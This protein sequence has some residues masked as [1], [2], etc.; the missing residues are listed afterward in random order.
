VHPPP[1]S[2]L[3]RARP[4]RSGAELANRWIS[5]TA[6]CLFKLGRPLEALRLAESAL[7]TSCSLD[8]QRF[9]LRGLILH[10]LRRYGDAIKVRGA[11][12]VGAAV[13]ESGGFAGRR[14]ALSLSLTTTGVSN[15]STAN[16]V[17]R[18]KARASV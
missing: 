17:L 13:I 2:S 1:F 4:R 14:V 9:Q 10:D 8:A 6:L 5:Q 12:E 11:H 15:N 18:F 3:N 16:P 7:K